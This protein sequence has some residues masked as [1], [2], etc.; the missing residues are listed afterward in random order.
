MNKSI[1]LQ[2]I[3]SVSGFLAIFFFTIFAS[4][5]S[6]QN[7]PIIAGPVLILLI[8]SFMIR[9]EYKNRMEKHDLDVM[10]R[11]KNGIK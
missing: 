8:L 5:W 10:K 2:S 6:L 4:I 11:L 7:Y 1:L 9:Y 3:K